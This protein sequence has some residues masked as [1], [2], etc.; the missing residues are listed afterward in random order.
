M[1]LASHFGSIQ[2]LAILGVLAAFAGVAHASTITYSLDVGT[3]ENVTGSGPG[4]PASGIV[5]GTITIDTTSDFP[6]SGDI[7]FNDGAV[8]NFE[9]TSLDGSDAFPGQGEG[10]PLDSS[11]T[12]LSVFVDYYTA[13]IGTGDLGIEY[14]AVDMAGT[15][16]DFSGTLNPTPEPSSLLLLG[17]GVLGLAGVARR[18]YLTA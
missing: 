17:T 12:L 9:F 1:S 10:D 16:Y 8:G 15:Y 6:V 3:A 14:G 18:R 5:S 7:L 4:V 2:R 11:N 13:N